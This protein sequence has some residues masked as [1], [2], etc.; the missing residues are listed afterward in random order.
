MR[1]HPVL[2][3][4]LI[5]VGI[6]L[7][8]FLLTYT[9]SS[10]GGGGIDLPGTEKI[11]VVEIKGVIMESRPIV[12][13]LIKFKKSRSIRGIVLRIDSPGGGVAPAQEIYEEVGKIKREKKVVASIESVGASGGYYIACA[14]DRIVANPGTI[15][16]S[17]GV[18]TEFVN[19]EQLLQKIGLK[20]FVVKSGKHKDIMSPTREPTEEDKKILQEVIDNIHNQFIDAVADG[21]KLDREK[22]VEI[23]DGRIF[24]GQQAR[25]LGLIDSLGNFQDA[26][27]LAARLAGIKGEPS[28]I[29]AEKKKP[30]LLDF[31]IQEAI[32]RVA[33]ELK[34][35][36]FTFGYLYVPP[37]F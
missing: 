29:Y 1:K 18:I 5:L 37:K 30:S 12:D 32:S 17:I 14:A 4:L 35:K 10:L 28:I 11:G 33:D 9:L 8:F 19:V 22:V 21:R 15:T 20:S 2:F 26:V 16:G 13:Q 34:K 7:G 23:A 3:G 36:E 25:D 6:F 31:F 24:S 27:A